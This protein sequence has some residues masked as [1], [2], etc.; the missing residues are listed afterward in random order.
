MT[1][2]HRATPEQFTAC[3]YDWSKADTEAMEGDPAFRCIL[4]LRARIEALEATQQP[5]HQD[6]LDRLMALDTD[7]GEPIVMPSSPADSLIDRVAKAI[8]D[9]PITSEGCR[10][11]ASAAILEVAAWL[12]EQHGGDSVASTMLWREANQ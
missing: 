2:P 10:S 8:Y 5:P 4:E 7:D 6:K 1:K 11:E 12:R 9:T 3:R